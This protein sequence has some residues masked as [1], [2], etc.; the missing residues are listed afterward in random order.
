MFKSA[1]TYMWVVAGLSCPSQFRD[2]VLDVADRAAAAERRIDAA[3]TLAV[4]M[5][6]AVGD[7][8]A[9]KMTVG[10]SYENI[11]AGWSLPLSAGA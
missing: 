2:A 7:A 3:Q 9:F 1:S 5:G 10:L 4:H 11:L 6:M 8:D